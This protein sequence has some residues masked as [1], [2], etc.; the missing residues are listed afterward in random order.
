MLGLLL[1][2]LLLWLGLLL[3]APSRS[4]GLRNTLGK[5]TNT[6][7]TPRGEVCT[8]FVSSPMSHVH[9]DRN[10]ITMCI[11]AYTLIPLSPGL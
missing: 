4:I 7:L 5:G 8:C 2:V 3:L 1:L 10:D 11:V 6:Y 9:K